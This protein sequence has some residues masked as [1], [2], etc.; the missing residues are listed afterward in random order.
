MALDIDSD[1][2]GSVGMNNRLERRITRTSC[3]I[4]AVVWSVGGRLSLIYAVSMGSLLVA[5]RDF[6]FILTAM[7]P[8]SIAQT[9][10]PAACKCFPPDHLSAVSPFARTDTAAGSAT[11]RQLPP[12]TKASQLC[13]GSSRRS[14]NSDLRAMSNPLPNAS[15]CLC[16]T[17][18][19][20]GLWTIAD[21]AS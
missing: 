8:I 19:L 9:S 10:A 13:G 20:F 15:C 1:G 12:I 5:G 14:L 11:A 6:R 21:R 7:L 17:A 16:V 18:F 4:G 3:Y 2:V